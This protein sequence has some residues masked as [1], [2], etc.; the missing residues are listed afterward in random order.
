MGYT[1]STE[2]AKNLI[3]K[4]TDNTKK[5]IDVEHQHSYQQ[6]QNEAGQAIH[7]KHFPV[8]VAAPRFLLPFVNIALF[9]ACASRATVFFP[10][11]HAGKKPLWGVAFNVA[12]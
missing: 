3:T 7:Q 6:D 10:R 11:R 5:S 9:A 2:N 12:Y 8:A 1:A 4:Q